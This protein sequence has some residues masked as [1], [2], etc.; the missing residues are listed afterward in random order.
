MTTPLLRTG[1]RTA[2]V[3]TDWTAW[4]ICGRLVVT[5]PSAVPLARAVLGREL[6]ALGRNF[7]TRHAT[8][9]AFRDGGWTPRLPDGHGIAPFPYGVTTAPV[10]EPVHLSLPQLRRRSEEGVRA[11][12]GAGR[13]LR[14]GLGPSL[15][16]WTAQRC[17]EAVA[18]ATTCGVLVAVGG[19]AATSGLAPAGGWRVEL[20]GG[21]NLGPEVL[22]LDGGAVSWTDLS[23]SGRIGPRSLV[24]AGGHTVRTHWRSVVVL[25]ANTPTANAA[26]AA[27]LLSGPSAPRLLAR[28]GLP[29]RLTS[30]DGRVR[31][32]GRWTEGDR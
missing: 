15:R 29:A 8:R 32:V 11:W 2:V 19:D 5:D 26:C 16:A 9:R 4:D 17:A 30:V 3:G 6:A 20:P 21:A 28:Q 18:E 1:P 10:G 31:D 25:A 22:A 13:R 12:M 24:V 23:R 7:R 27:A 14:I